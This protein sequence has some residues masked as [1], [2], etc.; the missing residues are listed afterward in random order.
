MSG[1][2]RLGDYLLWLRTGRAVAEPAQRRLFS[3][4]ASHKR[5]CSLVGN[6]VSDSRIDGHALSFHTG[7]ASFQH[8]YI[9]NPAAAGISQPCGLFCIGCHSS[10]EARKTEF[11]SL[12]DLCVQ[13]AYLAISFKYKVNAG[14]GVNFSRR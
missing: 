10:K 3:V 7:L 9:L 4:S 1:T 2:G 6:S 12:V 14:K 13:R 8:S 11:K 5:D